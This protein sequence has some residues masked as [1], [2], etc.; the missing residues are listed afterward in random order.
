MPSLGGYYKPL[1]KLKWKKFQKFWRTIHLNFSSKLP[2][3]SA[4]DTCE[5]VQNLDEWEQNLDAKGKSQGRKIYSRSQ[6]PL[7]SN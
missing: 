3:S 2:P 7:E 6:T 4:A 1:K 5:W